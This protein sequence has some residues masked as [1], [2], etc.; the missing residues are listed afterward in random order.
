MALMICSEC[1]GQV[2]SLAASCPHC[3]V[4]FASKP[5]GG[6][7]TAGRGLLLFLIG[8]AVLGAVMFDKEP[9]P[10]T[11]STL[12]PSATLKQT[13]AEAEMQ[14]Q[15]R[16]ERRAQQAAAKAEYVALRKARAAEFDSVMVAAGLGYLYSGTSFSMDPIPR[17]VFYVKDAWHGLSRDNQ[18][19]FVHQ[20][21]SLWTHMAALQNAKEDTS[22]YVIE[23]RHA[24]SNR[25][26]A[27]RVGEGQ[28]EIDSN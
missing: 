9:A 1:G 12:A 27:K 16:E 17:L 13:K 20:G 2:S 15:A 18:E 24:A 21:I 23:V 19:A 6:T 10:S 14:E 3:G 25:L 5:K 11:G 22:M 26:L 8:S 4:G 28:V 7:F